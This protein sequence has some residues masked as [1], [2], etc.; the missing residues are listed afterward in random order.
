[1]CLCLQWLAAPLY[2]PQLT[3]RKLLRQRA[4]GGVLLTSP[5]RHSSIAQPYERAPQV[6]GS[7]H[8]SHDSPPSVCSC[9]PPNISPSLSPSQPPRLIS[10]PSDVLVSGR[11]RM[12][13]AV[14]HMQIL[15]VCGKDMMACD[16]M[17]GA[18]SSC[19]WMVAATRALCTLMP[20]LGA[21]DNV[22]AGVA[23]CR[24]LL[25]WLQVARCVSGWLDLLCMAAS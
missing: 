8:P 1:M 13:P 16:V 15:L 17:N 10:R 14:C 5:R 2:A 18:G 22:A 25:Q 21:A 4:V 9:D 23:A 24:L 19:A 7:N 20:L 6:T 11:S 12:L 3:A